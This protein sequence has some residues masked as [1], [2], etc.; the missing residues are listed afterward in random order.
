MKN[1]LLCILLL[2]IYFS[3]RS[4]VFPAKN[5]P[6]G[7]FRDPLNIPISLAGNFGELRPNHYHM[8]LDIRTNKQ[9]NLP[10][11]AAADGYI[12]QI[13]VEPAGFGQAIYINHPN[14]YTTVYGHLNEFFPALAAYVKTQQY[15]ME[16]WRVFLNIPP[17]MFPVKKGDWIAY[18]GS[19]GGSQ[20]PHVHFEIRSTADDVNKNPMLFGMPIEDYT[21]PVILRLAVYDRTRGIY[22][23]QPKIFAT[24]RSGNEYVLANGIITVNSPKISFVISAFDT[25]SG[26]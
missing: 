1:F 18:S 25:E 4:Q 19:T 8:G 20:A 23:Q 21:A 22:E 2:I 12:A 14:G 24:K 13:D 6:K 10:V 17:G 5:Y 26:T 15:Q 11:Y 7:Y 16:S 9:V 3:A